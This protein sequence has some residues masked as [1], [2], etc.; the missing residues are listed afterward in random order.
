MWI[1]MS[2]EVSVTMFPYQ[3]GNIGL[4]PGAMMLILGAIVN[5]QMQSILFS[6]IDYYKVTNFIDLIEK[7]LGQSVKSIF[8]YT[9][10]LDIFS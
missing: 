5:Y 10:F 8:Q 6:A 1:R 4:L 2:L 9:Y 3:V 7:S